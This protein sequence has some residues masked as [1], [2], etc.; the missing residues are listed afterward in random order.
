NNNRMT[1][2]NTAHANRG[3]RCN[4]ISRVRIF[5]MF[6]LQD[7]PKVSNQCIGTETDVISK[8]QKIVKY[9]KQSYQTG[10]ELRSK[11]TNEIKRDRLK[12]YV[13]TR[14]TTAWD[15]TDSIL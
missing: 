8:C 9:F 1:V 5:K 13:I 12:T 10:E 6:C 15:C 3:I 2:T 11:I 7:G 14:W 4:E